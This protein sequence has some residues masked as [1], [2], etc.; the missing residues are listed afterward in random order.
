MS[1]KNI[2]YELKDG[3]ERLSGETAHRKARARIVSIERPFKN[4]SVIQCFPTLQ[5]RRWLESIEETSFPHFFSS[6]NRTSLEEFQDIILP[7]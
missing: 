6:V 5:G 4:L 1:M 2:C 3:T 7:T